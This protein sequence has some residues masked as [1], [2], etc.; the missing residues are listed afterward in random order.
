ML[1]TALTPTAESAEPLRR[2]RNSATPRPT[3]ATTTFLDRPTWI[4]PK[5]RR[6][7]PQSNMP[8]DKGALT[9]PPT[10]FDLGTVAFTLVPESHFCDAKYSDGLFIEL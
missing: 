3:I 10:D 9:D 1:D 6:T 7:P 4:G 2:R 8:A 5:N